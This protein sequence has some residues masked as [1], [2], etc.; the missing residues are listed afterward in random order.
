M[1]DASLTA[2]QDEH[3]FGPTLEAV[4]ARVRA[5][6]GPPDPFSD[7]HV[8]LRVGDVWTLLAALD[9]RRGEREDER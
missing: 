2:E 4:L 7:E 5:E 1:S 6:V 8:A 3:L 9:W